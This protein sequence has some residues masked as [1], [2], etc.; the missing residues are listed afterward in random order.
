MQTSVVERNKKLSKRYFKPFQ[1]IEH[2][3]QVSYEIKLPLSSK[4][5]LVFHV[6]LL[7]PYKG[8]PPKELNPLP[9]KSIG[10]KPIIQPATIIDHTILNSGSNATL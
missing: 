9:P 4:F 1:I 7:K 5:H 3:V 6:S 10:N 8:G 2:V